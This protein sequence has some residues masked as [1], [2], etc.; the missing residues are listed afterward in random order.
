M[1]RGAAGGVL[2]YPEDEHVGIAAGHGWLGRL[3][4]VHCAAGTNGVAI[5]H[6]NGFETAARTAWYRNEQGAE[7]IPLPSVFLFGISDV[8][9]F[10]MRDVLTFRG[11]MKLDAMKRQ[12]ARMDL[13]LCQVGTKSRADE[14]P[15]ESAEDT[16]FMLCEFLFFSSRSIHL[17]N[18]N[19]TK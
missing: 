17:R 7:E 16:S 15:A 13:T 9:A 6:R 18:T 11:T 10:L 3:P 8:S 5:S 1:G 12:G 14:L 19:K 2:F 4:V